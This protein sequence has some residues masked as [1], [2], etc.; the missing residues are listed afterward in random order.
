VCDCKAGG[1]DQRGAGCIEQPVGA[2]CHHDNDHEQRVEHRDDAR[3]GRSYQTKREDGD[4]NRPGNVQTGHGGVWVVG[5][6]KAVQP[7]VADERVHG[8]S[9][10]V[11]VTVQRE[12]AD[13]ARRR[14]RI[15]F[16]A[17]KRG[18]VGPQKGVAQFAEARPPPHVD[19][20]SKRTGDEQVQCSVHDVCQGDHHRPANGV[21]SSLEQGSL[22]GGLDQETERIL[23]VHHVM[24]MLCGQEARR[25]EEGATE[26]IF[27]HLNRDHEEELEGEPAPL[28]ERGGLDGLGARDSAGRSGCPGRDGA[29]EGMSH[30]AQ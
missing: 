6:R 18:D 7:A 28:W 24:R 25:R 14:Q 10:D 30:G 16:V 11:G 17:G 13:K 3:R 26:G 21:W 29:L 15:E 9:H 19:P 12:P 23:E 8:V 5:N 27:P 20:G 4:Q 22:P 1:S 2:G